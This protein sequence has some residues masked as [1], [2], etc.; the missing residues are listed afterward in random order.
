MTFL[1]LVTFNKELAENSLD[2]RM[3]VL[4][5]MS[6]TNIGGFL[7][8]DTVHIPEEKLKE[9]DVKLSQSEFFKQF[10]E[11]EKNPD[12]MQDLISKLGFWAFSPRYIGGDLGYL[13]PRDPNKDPSGTEEDAFIIDSERF[14]YLNQCIDQFHYPKVIDLNMDPFEKETSVDKKWGVSCVYHS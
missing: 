3:L 13:K 11:V 9:Y 10:K 8:Q 4:H 12:E 2:A 1:T 6:R 7:R 5:F 14:D